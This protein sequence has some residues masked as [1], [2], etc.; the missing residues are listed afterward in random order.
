MLQGRRP[1]GV[2]GHEARAC[3]WQGK[4]CQA[5]VHAFMLAVSKARELVTAELVGPGIL[6]AGQVRKH[7]LDAA[8]V[9]PLG[10]ELEE[11]CDGL[12]GAK[13]L[14]EA[15]F[16]RAVVRGGGHAET[17]VLVAQAAPGA[18]QQ[19]ELCEHL[20]AGNVFL[21][22]LRKEGPNSADVVHVPG[23]GKPEESG[24]GAGPA[25][26]AHLAPLSHGIGGAH[27]VQDGRELQ[28]VS[29]RE[30]HA[31]CEPAQCG[32]AVFA[33]VHLVASGVRNADVSG[34][35]SDRHRGDVGFAGNVA[36]AD[37]CDARSP[38]QPQ[39]RRAIDDLG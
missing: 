3:G 6:L 27:A 4:I 8:C 1:G 21:G 2:C 20:E 7:Q 32:L 39:A 22:L 38:L 11:V 30:L 5:D 18:L 15:G 35:V 24:G 19:G 36:G 31:R 9:R 17:L 10:G 34:L 28:A 16:A 12:A 37:G 13:K 23:A 26:D 29:G 14:V 25:S 33:E